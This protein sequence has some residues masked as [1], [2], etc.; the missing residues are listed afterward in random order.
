MEG[1]KEDYNVEGDKH[2]IKPCTSQAKLIN[3]PWNE[4]SV[5]G[6]GL[7]SSTVSDFLNIV[8]ATPGHCTNT[9]AARRMLQSSTIPND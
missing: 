1:K 8:G 3:I 7:D 6:F 9:F 4:K 2:L 5:L